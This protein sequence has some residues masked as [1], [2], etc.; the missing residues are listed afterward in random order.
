MADTGSSK[1]SAEF[2]IGI[3]TQGLP[4]GRFTASVCISSVSKLGVFVCSRVT[5]EVVP[6]PADEAS[7]SWSFSSN[8]PLRLQET[9]FEVGLRSQF[10]TP[11]AIGSTG[12]GFRLS[13]TLLDR[14]CLPTIAGACDGSIFS[15]QPLTNLTSM[16]YLFR[17][18]PGLLSA[19]NYSFSLELRVTARPRT[20]A[21]FRA[22]F[23]PQLCDGENVEPTPTTGYGCI[24]AAGFGATIQG[25]CEKCVPGR[26]RS[27]S[28]GGASVCSEC[29]RGEITDVAGSTACRQVSIACTLHHG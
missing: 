5:L 11:T 25:L 10:G 22:E 12:W 16:G 26:F 21:S 4:V 8:L 15:D 20:I 29:P 14:N 28:E 13:W 9:G 7:S 2:S 6:G 3:S 18:V 27:V 24:C 1:A 23:L 17:F 19:G